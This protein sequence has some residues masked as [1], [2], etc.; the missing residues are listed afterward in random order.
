MA[1]RPCARQTPSAPAGGDEPR[2]RCSGPWQNGGNTTAHGAL[3]LRCRPALPRMRPSESQGRGPRPAPTRRATG[4]RRKGPRGAPSRECEI[5]PRGAAP[6]RSI[7]SRRRP[8]PAARAGSSSPTGS[9]GKSP[10]PAA[11]SSGCGSPRNAHKPPPEHPPAP[12]APLARDH[13]PARSTNCCQ[14]SRDLEASYDPRLPA[15]LRHAPA[16]IRNGHPNHPR[17]P[18]ARQR[19]DDD[20]LPPPHVLNRGP[21]GV[22]S[23]L[24]GL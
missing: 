19:V 2:G 12:S 15:L 14:G 4:E 21:P 9:R 10:A 22:R 7:A 6:P 17:A 13:A 20:D 16:R 23:S 18:R 3:A 11:R 24:D 1:G 5:E 8:P